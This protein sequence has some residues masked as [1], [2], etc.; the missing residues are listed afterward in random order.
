MRPPGNDAGH[1]GRGGSL[2]LWRN[3]PP[4]RRLAP[5]APAAVLAALLA[6]SVA[7]QDAPQQ[8]ADTPPDA[9]PAVPQPKRPATPA[10][11]PAD[12]IPAH[13]DYASVIRLIRSWAAAAPDLA[14]VE[15]YGTSTKGQPLVCLQ[16]TS[17]SGW[18]IIKST[19]Q[20]VPPPAALIH[21]CIHGNEPL[22]T[23]VVLAYVAHLLA[24][25]GRDDVCTQALESR[26]IV[27]VPVVCPDSFPFARASDGKDPNRVWADAQ[28]VTAVAAMQKLFARVQPAACWSGHTSGRQFLT[29]LGDSRERIPEEQQYAD[30]FARMAKLANYQW[31]HACELYGRPIFGAETDWYYRH[32]ACAHVTE[33]GTHQHAPS[34]ADT[35]AEFTRTWPA[36]LLWLKEAPTLAHKRY[37]QPATD[38][39]T[40]FPS[41]RPGASPCRF[42]LRIVSTP[43]AQ[44]RTTTPIGHN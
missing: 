1:P 13:R 29:P 33:Y 21:A 25:Y 11:P 38:L 42:P 17:P 23:S 19:G 27:L 15:Q 10:I 31:L 43:P 14:T 12:L 39:F 37:T 30:L 41:L 32:G 9:P 28:P 8:P 44:Q 26:Q 5:L 16:L 24:G 35:Q 7:V 2:C 22:S 34:L 6:V 36:F 20:R 40:S 4:M 3:R 18:P